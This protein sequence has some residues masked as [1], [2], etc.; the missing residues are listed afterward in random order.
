MRVS[1]QTVRNTAF[2]LTGTACAWQGLKML[3][4][5][6]DLTP[7]LFPYLSRPLPDLTGESMRTRTLVTLASTDCL[8]ATCEAHSASV[9]TTC[10]RIKSVV[11]HQ[12]LE[13]LQVDVLEAAEVKD[14]ALRIQTLFKLY[15]EMASLLTIQTVAFTEIV[16]FARSS[17]PI[18]SVEEALELNFTST[19]RTSKALVPLKLLIAACLIG[20]V[21]EGGDL[22]KLGL[23]D[24]TVT[25]LKKAVSSIEA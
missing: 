7:S 12:T 25:A 11:G 16:D 19:E 5:P 2:A 23:D 20:Y 15:Q 14:P 21:S 9:F 3:T 13:S 24:E 1:F 8:K 10:E 17:P 18:R 6:R 22:T 4:A